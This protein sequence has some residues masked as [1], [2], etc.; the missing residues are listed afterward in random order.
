MRPGS[1]SSRMPPP[2]T[3]PPSCRY[4]AEAV[5][6]ALGDRTKDAEK[7][8]KAVSKVQDALGE[9]QDGIVALETI[10]DAMAGTRRSPKF[11]YAAG[12]M[13]ERQIRAVE[14]SR[15][16]FFQ[17]WDDVDRKRHRRW[18]KQ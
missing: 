2:R 13:A 4:A 8:A 3:A 10:E 11:A 1:R 15:A 12:R 14:E 7:Y 18:L 9:H 17:A 6:P 5:A 16:S